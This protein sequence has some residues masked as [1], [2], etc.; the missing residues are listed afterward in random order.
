M[1]TQTWRL[2]A[3]LLVALALVAGA[4]CG[5]DDDEEA[6]AS[7]SGSET[8]ETTGDAG[9]DGAEGEEA[10]GDGDIEAYCAKTLEIE[11]LPEPE[12]DF[13]TASPEEQAEAVKAYAA[14][15]MT[16]IA[17]EIRA[18]APEEVAADI[19][20]L[21]GAVEELTETGDF[22]AVFGTPAVEEASDNAHAFDLENC[23]WEQVDVT[24]VDYAFEG[25]DGSI[26]AGATSFE[27]TNDTEN[28]EFHEL[29][30]FRKNDDT[31]ESIQELLELP[32]EEAMT[33]VT[34]AGGTFAEPGD[35]EYFVTELEPGDYAAVCFIPVGASP[36]NE[37]GNGPPHF[38]QGMVTEFTVE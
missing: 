27:F 26:P 9:E 22:E 14:E 38:V 24:G 21:V 12:V 32:Q 10:S 15:E 6:T 16:P 28:G 17:E 3:R 4:A 36:E 5:G 11:T 29:V 34:E 37:E 8:T 23:G 18:A 19:E 2:L 7:G 25:L 31:T 35:S 30:V 13:E 20:V 33:K 1:N